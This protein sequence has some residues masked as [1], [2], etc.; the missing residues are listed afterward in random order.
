MIHAPTPAT[1][2]SPRPTAFVVL[3][4]R[5]ALQHT[6]TIVACSPYFDVA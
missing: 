5:Q 1:A 6:A 3:H 4:V 2:A